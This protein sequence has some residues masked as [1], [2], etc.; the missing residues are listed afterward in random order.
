MEV[1]SRCIYLAG[2]TASPTGTWVVQQ[3][4][5]LAWLLQDGKIR[6]RLLL[7]DR[8]SKFT[9]ASTRSSVAKAWKSSV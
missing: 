7:R 8:D 4:R 6:A 3:T 1:A 9:S 2:C 5:Q